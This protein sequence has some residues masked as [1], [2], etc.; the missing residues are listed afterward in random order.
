MARSSDST[1]AGHLPAPGT[2]P[3][4]E[5]L[6]RVAVHGPGPST[7]A[8][9]GRRAEVVLAYLAAE[10][11]RVVSQDELADALWP[12]QLPDTW[13]A[14]LRG[15][16][17]DVRRCLQEAGLDGP[18]V[19]TTARRGYQLR[20]PGGTTVD[21]DEA[22]QSLALASAALEAGHGG[23]AAVHAARAAALARLPFLPHHDGEW[24]DG[25]R[26][27]LQSLL[28]RALDAQ[29]RGHRAASDL[30]A[31][32]AAAEQLV[33]VEP[34]AEGGHQLRIRVLGEAGDRAGAIRA[35]E[36]CRGV[37]AEELGV[38]PSVGTKAALDDAM[39]A[40]AFET[41]QRPGPVPAAPPAATA[42]PETGL[43]GDLSVLVVEDHDFQRRTAVRLLRGLGVQHVYEAGD[44]VEALEVLSDCPQPDVIIC[45]IDM[46]AMDGVQFI[47]R[48][49]E[50]GLA[51][52]VII[53]SGLD[54]KV[55][56]AVKAIGESHGV[57]LLGAVEKPLTPRRLSELL[58]TY[59]RHPVATPAA[60]GVS[61]S[62]AEVAAAIA[63]RQLRVAFDPA[64]DLG[65]CRVSGAEAVV[66]WDH[67]SKGR[68]P[69]GVF[70]PVVVAEGLLPTY[71]E[72]VLDE[73]SAAVTSC[74]SA[75]HPVTIGVDVGTAALGDVALADRFVETLRRRGVTPSDL[76]CE[77]SEHTLPEAPTAALDAMTRLRVKGFGLALD[78]LGARRLSPERLAQ[79]P[80]TQ[81][82]VDAALVAGA[83][84]EPRRRALLEETLDMARSLAGTVVAT[85]CACE[86][87]FDLVV[88]LGF[89]QAQGP[90]VGTALEPAALVDVAT[91]WRPPPA[92][93]AAG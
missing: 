47:S 29:A 89:D 80:F 59:R 77:V 48:V 16:V 2:T 58:A 8:P 91:G 62:P 42:A 41:V 85:G 20:L 30:A 64:V 78:H 60:G 93:S 57:T 53:A 81:A 49:A 25:I 73:V 66:Y 13:S 63:G 92:G 43:P 79:I 45:D 87:D 86:A 44:G 37:L 18:V 72:T 84:C 54:T 46:P 39:R 75:G 35:Y 71:A 6:G 10:H 74:R 31:A 15:V 14:A 26:R 67:P 23:D 40:I 24:V 12:G 55:L 50:H 17:T 27:E 11:R 4:V 88:E 21:L 19:L 70:L 61:V 90:F 65:E 9:S 5:L 32:A 68:L 1:E 69:S 51:S 76:T 34:F 56:A 82:K 3:R 28:A 52:A 36:H 33:R 22:R 7:G 83:S 38:E